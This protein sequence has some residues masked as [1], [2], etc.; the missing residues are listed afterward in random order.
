MSAVPQHTNQTDPT[1]FVSGLPSPTTLAFE[2]LMR[3]LSDSGYPFIG[4]GTVWG[5]RLPQIRAAADQAPSS[6]ALNADAQAVDKVSAIEGQS[7][8]QVATRDSNGVV[9]TNRD[10]IM[11]KWAQCEQQDHRTRTRPRLNPSTHPAQCMSAS[12]AWHLG[13]R[14]VV[15]RSADEIERAPL[16]VR[17]T[18]AVAEMLGLHGD[19]GGGRGGTNRYRS[20]QKTISRGDLLWAQSGA[21]PWAAYE[22]GHVAE[23][24]WSDVQAVDAL[25]DAIVTYVR[26]LD[27]QA[28]RTIL[29]QVRAEHLSNAR[30]AT[31]VR[32]KLRDPA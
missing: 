17:E 3:Q 21:W 12:A 20:L 10:K 27:A 24:W 13:A 23:D 18:P 1:P 2:L 6:E 14:R 7:W 8:F 11:E 16:V 29:K 25:D 31:A 28:C 9:G 15:E 19:L 32:R 4:I 5:P 22:A 26:W 30:W